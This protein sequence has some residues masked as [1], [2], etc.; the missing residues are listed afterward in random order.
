MEELLGWLSDG[1]SR[2]G[3]RNR[4]CFMFRGEEDFVQREG[5]SWRLG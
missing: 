3:E 5:H 1:D 4:L 2:M